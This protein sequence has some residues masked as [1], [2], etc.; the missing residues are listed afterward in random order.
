MHRPFEQ[1]LK[2]LTGELPNPESL[3]DDNFDE[4]AA[5]A[6]AEADAA[7]SSICVMNL[8]MGYVRYHFGDPAEASKHLEQARA[9]LDGAPSVWHP[10]TVHQYAALAAGAA[11][12]QT[13]DQTQRQAYLGLIEQ[14]LGALR[15]L[16][17]LTPINFAH[18][19]SLVEAELL[20]M[21]G[22]LSGALAKLEQAA[23][24]AQEGSW[25]NDV[26]I[27][28]EL[29]ARCHRDPELAKKSLRSG[30]TA[31]AAWGANAKVQQ[32]SERI[33]RLGA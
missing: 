6:K 22:N 33:A 21:E 27:A 1:L 19:V 12:H 26:A 25:I 29:A 2:A 7:R 17:A 9:H 4:H 11:W 32:L 3:S 15:R 24:Q 8:T 5:L 23:L 18:R 16:A 14:S 20:R 10:P 28:H 30:R 13:D 31:Y